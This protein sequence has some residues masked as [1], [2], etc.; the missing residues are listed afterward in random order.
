MYT[1]DIGDLAPVAL[2]E[3]H[4]LRIVVVDEHGNRMG[5]TDQQ[6]STGTGHRPAGRSCC[7]GCP[8]VAATIWV[9]VKIQSRATPVAVT[10]LVPTCLST[11]HK[12]VTPAADHRG[13]V[14]R[15]HVRSLK[16]SCLRSTVSIHRGKRSLTCRI[17]MTRTIRPSR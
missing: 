13:L 6:E 1:I 5:G 10:R 7:C 15:G 3:A 8:V 16:S 9:L 11:S 2:A 14:L 17:G 12:P 4:G